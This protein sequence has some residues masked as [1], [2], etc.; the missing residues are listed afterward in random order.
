MDTIIQAHPIGNGLDNF[1]TSL[2]SVCEEK[3]IPYIADAVGQLS[4]EDLRN[5]TL[6]LLFAL[7]G[8]RASRHLRSHGR[9]ESLSDDLT[10]L[11]PFIRSKAFSFDRI[12]PLLKA[13]LANETD[14]KIWTQV[15]NAVVESTPPP[16][17]S[18]PTIASLKTQTPWTRNSGSPVNSSEHRKN[19]DHILKQELDAMHADIPGFHETF[20]GDMAELSENIFRKCKARPN[21]LFREGEGWSEWPQNAEEAAVLTWLGNITNKLAA[22]TKDIDSNFIPQQWPV[23]QPTKQLGGPTAAKRKLDIGFIN[24]NHLDDKVIDDR[25]YRRGQERRADDGYGRGGPGENIIKCHWSQIRIPGE[26][27]SNPD[28]DKPS[29]ARLDLGRY[30]REVMSAQPTR[31]FVLSFTLC[32]SVMRVW[33]FDRVGAIASKPFDINQDGKQFILTILGFL[34]MNKEQLGFDPT[35]QKEGDEHFINIQRDGFTEKLILGKLIMHQ[36]CIVG[37]ATTCW[38]A[39]IKDS[40]I[41]LVI[42]D[43][44]Q[45]LERD[46]EG[47]LLREATEKKVTNVARYYHHEI[48]HI[49]GEIDDVQEKIR[50][51]LDIT[52]ANLIQLGTPDP[53]PSTS[54]PGS[55]TGST[56]GTSEQQQSIASGS[57]RTSSQA[58]TTL[59]ASKRAKLTNQPPLN[60]VHRRLIIRDYG[61]PIYYASS[62][63]ALLNALE[64]CIAGHESLYKANLLHRDI[65]INNLMINEDDDNPSWPSFLID[66]DLAVE[67]SRSEASGARGRTGTRAFMAIGVLRGEQ[68]S[69]MH[70]LESFFWVLFWICIHYEGP[71]KG[72]IVDDFDEWNYMKMEKLAWEKAGTVSERESITERMTGNFTSYFQ[73]LIPWVTKLWEVAFPGGKRHYLDDEK[74]YSQMRGILREASKEL[75]KTPDGGLAARDDR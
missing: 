15:Y 75:E 46:E 11:Y 25:A 34:Y 8:L 6:D 27:K 48:V 45:Y 30:V 66:L 29:Q 67:R 5:I 20:F 47:E 54:T 12:E 36:Y 13:V 33:Q 37:R 31:R 19:M 2:K 38:K 51:G 53:S 57:K 42:K 14:D 10:T 59:P 68:H 69:F 71:G 52:H 43:S 64:G 26:L 62:P 61:K 21:Q 40:D 65:S 63:S 72:R 49:G 17:P 16:K 32:G 24:T 28:A 9:G 23:A 39:C 55:T 50:H 41:P 35:F 44:W 22:L 73:P 70:D 7:L 4:Q 3:Q 60:R 1:R 58:N 18:H 56:K 74:L